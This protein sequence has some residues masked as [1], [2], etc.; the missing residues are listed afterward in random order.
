MNLLL[1]DSLYAHL[2]NL[3]ILNTNYGTYV[4]FQSL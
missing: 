1:A 4:G 2:E 3:F